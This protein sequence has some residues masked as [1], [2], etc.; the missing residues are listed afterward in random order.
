V[1]LR[2]SAT[3]FEQCAAIAVVIFFGVC[4]ISLRFDW[5]WKAVDNFC[6]CDELVLKF[7]EESR[8]GF[9]V[10][11]RQPLSVRVA[12]PAPQFGGRGPVA[13]VD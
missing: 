4:H 2:K 7:G 12:M 11:M 1:R 6:R 10:A 9:V 8:D 5:C 3:T 13:G